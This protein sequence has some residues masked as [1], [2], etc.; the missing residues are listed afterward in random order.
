MKWVRKKLIWPQKWV[1]KNRYLTNR[2]TPQPR[3]RFKSYKLN[4]NT[5]LYIYIEYKILIKFPDLNE[6]ALPTL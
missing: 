2:L 1:K 5:S 6:P 3:R 4:K